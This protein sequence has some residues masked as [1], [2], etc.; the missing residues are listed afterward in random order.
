MDVTVA[1][2]CLYQIVLN[3]HSFKHPGN[4]VLKAGQTRGTY[5]GLNGSKV[6][7]P[8]VLDHV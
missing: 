7:L 8:C 6:C 3:L 5:I 2:G 1:L 4:V